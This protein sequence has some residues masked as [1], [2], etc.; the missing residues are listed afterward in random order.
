M[1]VERVFLGWDGFVTDKLCAW[2]LPERPGRFVDLGDRLIVVPTHQ[3]AR[4]L[5]AALAAAC[6]DRGA[7]LLS[8]KVV[9]PAEFLRPAPGEPPEADALVELAVWRD[10]LR[11][12]P[13]E[14]YPALFPHP[15]AVRDDAWSL[16]AARRLRRVRDTL[17]DEGWAVPDVPARAGAELPDPD[18][19][20]ELA[21]I[22]RTAAD[23]LAALGLRDP[24][25]GR[26]ARA[27]RPA[28]PEGVACILLAAVPDPAPLVLRALRELAREIPVTVLIHA[29][30]A[31]A[32]DY[33]D[34]GLIRPER[35][36]A[37]TIV[38]AD[39]GRDLCV[40]ADPA[41]QARQALRWMADEASRWGP[42]DVALGVPDPEVTAPLRRELAAAGLAAFDPA[43]QPVARHPLGRLMRAW[44]DWRAS[45]DAAATAALLRQPDVLA[46][47][48]RAAGLAADRVLAELDELRAVHLPD[49]FADLQ[50]AA[51]ARHPRLRS[52]LAWLAAAPADARAWLQTV[53]AAAPLRPVAAPADAEFC[54]VAES[55]RA[56]LDSAEAAARRLPGLDARGLHSLALDEWQAGAYYPE[57]DDERVDLEGWLELPW[58][59]APFMIVTGLNEGRVPDWRAADEFLPDGLRRALGLRDEAFRAARDLALL[60]GLAAARADGRGRL[61][62]VAGRV[63]AAA[64]P[65]A[66]SRL[67]FACDD[68]E[69]PSRARAV[70]R[71]PGDPRPNHPAENSLRLDVRPPAAWPVARLRPDRLSVTQFQ[72]YLACPFRFYLR[73]ILGMEPL[74]ERAR[75]LDP[76]RFGTM[77][78]EALRLLGEDPRL[79]ACGDAA[80][81]ADAL[82]AAAERWAHREIGSP[83][84]LPVD[85]QLAA[86]RQ[87]LQAAA[88]EQ[89]RLAAEGWT[90]REC[91]WTCSGTI[92]GLPVSGRIDRLDVHADGRWRIVDY[93]SGDRPRLPAEAHYGPRRERTPDFACADVGGRSRA[94]VNLQLPLYRLLLR[95]SGHPAGAAGEV[96]YFN[97]PKAVSDTGVAVWPEMDDLAVDSAETCASGVVRA[98]QDLRYWPPNEAGW[99]WDDDLARLFPDGPEAGVR[100]PEFEAFLDAARAAGDRT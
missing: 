79:A 89:V 19:W 97:L 84:P 37:R 68:A 83:A 32:D 8:P 3:A 45:G 9:T 6:A 88:R 96:A 90:I 62:L 40:A 33:D 35:W 46:A 39:P 69:L 63:S 30:A 26:L 22:G 99:I 86:A 87:R 50:A 74:D 85:L 17:L 81:I 55:L 42:G 95:Q 34:W 31:A 75:E 57:P 49:G 100:A 71:N 21:R 23:N 2:L 61:A 76:A 64:E 92:A 24:A 82:I 28:R 36:T 66:P 51:G 54:Q 48:R 15:P 44:E 4:R 14:E 43:G 20:R 73:H 58:N 93:K 52:A 11:N 25:A 78:H 7:A 16:A 77:L 41:G 70:F 29:P 38:F 67:L 18:R 59:D 60:A 56:A 80:R 10:T 13:L 65:L 72:D 98:I 47:L 27:A 1:G 91:E 5:R 53:Y 94:W 12:L